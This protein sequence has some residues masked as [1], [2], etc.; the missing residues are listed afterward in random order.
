MHIDEDGSSTYVS[1]NKR[2]IFW[3]DITRLSVRIFLTSFYFILCFFFQGLI[4]YVWGYTL[5]IYKDIDVNNGIFYSDND[6]LDVSDDNDN[7]DRC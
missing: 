3:R 4:Y 5:F 1:S 2:R 6:R 7:D